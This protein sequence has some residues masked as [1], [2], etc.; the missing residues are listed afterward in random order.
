MPEHPWVLLT[1]AATGLSYYANTETKETSWEVPAALGGSDGMACPYVRLENGWFQYSDDQTGRAYYYNVHTRA[2]EWARPPEARA[3]KGSIED[4]YVSD[5][6]SAPPP[7]PPGAL[8]S[9]KMGD[10]DDDDIDGAEDDVIVRHHSLVRETADGDPRLE[11]GPEEDGATQEAEAAR[12]SLKE[13]FKAAEK[14]ARRKANRVNNLKEFVKSERTYVDKLHVLEKVFVDP[15]RMV[16]DPG[17]TQWA[18][19]SL[20]CRPATGYSE[21]KRAWRRA[22]PVRLTPSGQWRT[23]EDS[24]PTVCAQVADMPKGAIFS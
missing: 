19:P 18:L 11:A 23:V 13:A 10:D 21:A 14:S 2:T 16:A 5:D 4:D 1:D 17:R 22:S 9:S 20:H 7:T 3:R 6:E 24:V 15:L 12:L 8:Q